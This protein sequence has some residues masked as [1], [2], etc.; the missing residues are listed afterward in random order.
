MRGWWED[1]KIDPET[2][3]EL[4]PNTNK[5]LNKDRKDTIPLIIIPLIIIPLFIIPLFII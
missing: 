4:V 3:C 5:N 1:E 2:L